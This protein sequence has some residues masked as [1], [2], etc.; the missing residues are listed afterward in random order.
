MS[1]REIIEL[2]AL[3][4][5][6]LGLIGTLFGAISR[7]QLKEFIIEKMEEI[8]DSG[9]SS[10]EKLEYVINAVKEKYKILTIIINIQKFVEKVLIRWK[11]TAF[12][13]PI[14]YEG[15]RKN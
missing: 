3:I 10:V 5:T 14:Y 2:V 15:V 4:I 1:I 11:K 9:K 7:G 8:E 6:T 13:M 12:L